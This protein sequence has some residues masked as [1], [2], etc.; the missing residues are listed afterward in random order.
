[1]ARQSR[2][3]LFPIALS[4]AMLAASVHISP[5]VV[6]RAI[7]NGELRVFRRG[8]ARRILIMEAVFW[9]ERYW[10]LKPSNAS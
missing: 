7:K 5:D 8:L 1:M 4:P 6:Y 10:K 9:I 3:P 2:T